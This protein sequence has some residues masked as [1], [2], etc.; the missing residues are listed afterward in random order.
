MASNSIVLNNGVAVPKLAY[1]T[2]TK[3]FKRAGAGAGADA[4]AINDE[5]VQSILVA[6]RSGFR[7]IDSAEGYGTEPEVGKAL[8]LFFAE[9]GLTRADVF[10]TTKVSPPPSN[11]KQALE[12]SLKKLGP[13]AGGYVDL[14]LIHS[15]FWD[16]EN[17]PPSIEKAWRDLESLVLETKQVRAIG[18]SN[19]RIKDFE[20]VAAIKPRVYPSVN[21]I[22]YHAYLQN[23]NLHAYLS[24]PDSPFPKVVTAAY[25]PLQP[26]VQFAEIGR[27]KEAVERIAASRGNGTTGSQV[28]LAWVWQSR[29]VGG[30]L[31][32]TTSSKEERLR[33]AVA[34]QTLVL[35]DVEVAEITA[36]AE[37]TKRRKF[38][39]PKAD[40]FDD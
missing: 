22:E 36:S 31:V 3:W 14:Y 1:G 12:N 34:A 26:L 20:A 29:G 2:G 10:I 13:A 39:A 4:A 33:E 27:V 35:N 28:L 37:G 19:W 17:T 15:P 25:G 38:F 30:S 40:Q 11:I 21:Q 9:S 6:L 7:H 32:V 16:Y 24:K 8:E 23:E 5:L 18:V